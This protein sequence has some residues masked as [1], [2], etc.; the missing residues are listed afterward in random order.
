MRCTTLPL[1]HQFKNRYCPRHLRTCLD[2]N[3]QDQRRAT[4]F[5][6]RAV[7]LGTLILLG[8][9]PAQA[10]NWPQWRGPAF[11]G[12]SDETSLPDNWSKTENI[13]WSAPLPGAAAATP[14]VWDD[15]VFLS[16]V[17]STKDTLQA[18][19]F[20]RCT[21]RLLWTR[22]VA[23]GTRR[24]HRSNYASGSPVTDGQ[25]VVFLYG[26][27][28]LICYDFAG[29]LCWRWNLDRELGPFAFYWTPASSPL[30]HAG[31]LYIE[32]LQRDVPVAGRG[33][34]DRENVSFLLAIDPAT[35][36]TLWR[37]IRPTRAVSESHESYTTPIPMV[38][39]G[40]SQLL[41]AGGDALSAHDPASGK[42]LWRWD[43]WNPQRREHWP[44]VASPVTGDGV[45]LVCVPKGQPVYAIKTDGTGTLDEHAIAW[46]SRNDRQ[47]TSEVPTPAFYD[48]DFF[49]LSESKKA[50]TRV[51]ARTGK[52][53]WTMRTPGST[54]YEASPLAADGK[55]LLINWDGQVSIVNAA[56]G[57]VLRKISM[58][59]PAEG[60]LVRASIIASHG[61][62]FIRTTRHLYCVGA[63]PALPAACE[64]RGCRRPCGD[65][66]GTS[67]RSSDGR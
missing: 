6:A 42:E 3:G 28:E 22:D 4:R 34:T 7:L 51:E 8:T 15:H 63:K 64:P 16:G 58:D 47:I 54:T 62:L 65:T 66:A 57:D 60:E 20:D 13:A 52:V 10:G 46:A 48:G 23:Q 5:V 55:I 59:Q 11:N 44:L 56:T 1:V 38:V 35:G 25:R 32:V 45:A 19:C 36:K 37:H 17:D 2:T 61:Q 67:W 31:T 49:I 40:Q 33:Q 18:M 12:S 27:G 30:L 50:L 41:V 9:L 14:I 24:D 53:K 43:G 26:N 21:G 39:K 29:K